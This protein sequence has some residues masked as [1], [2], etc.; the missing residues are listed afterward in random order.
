MFVRNPCSWGSSSSSSSSRSVRM[1]T[2]MGL[3]SVG[4]SGQARTPT[5]K[6][7]EVPYEHVWWEFLKQQM[8]H[9]LEV[10]VIGN[11][12][13]VSSYIPGIVLGPSTCLDFYNQCL[14][15]AV[16]LLSLL[17]F[18][19]GKWGLEMLSNSLP[20]HSQRRSQDL[21][22]GSLTPSPSGKRAFRVSRLPLTAERPVLTA[23]ALSL[24][25]CTT[26][27]I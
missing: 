16:D 12:Y 6:G 27:S 1:E 14:L 15:F 9:L 5:K 3:S 2:Q 25:Q 23:I 4:G 21:N 17:T 11:V 7:R 13:R 10:M 24:L 20:S 22:S 8:Q 26:P 18:G 19:W